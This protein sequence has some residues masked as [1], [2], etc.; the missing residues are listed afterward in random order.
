MCGA[1]AAVAAALTAF[2][3]IG[4]HAHHC[5]Q[6]EASALLPP[7]RDARPESAPSL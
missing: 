3:M 1:A 4:V 2:G 6:D 7:G 5:A